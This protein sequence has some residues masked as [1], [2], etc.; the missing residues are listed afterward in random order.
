MIYEFKLQQGSVAMLQ[1]E[2]ILIFIH[3]QWDRT[4]T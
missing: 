2:Y 3:M 1:T 4:Q